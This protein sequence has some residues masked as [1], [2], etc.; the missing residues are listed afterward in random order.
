MVDTRSLEAVEAEQEEARRNMSRGGSGDCKDCDARVET[1][2][3]VSL[4]APANR[5]FGCAYSLRR[6]S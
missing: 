5:C 3:G 2:F 4:D 1:L 6:P